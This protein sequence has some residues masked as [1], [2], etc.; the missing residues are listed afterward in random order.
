[1]SG[2]TIKRKIVL[3][4]IITAATGVLI[5]ITV[6]LFFIFK[7]DSFAVLSGKE[8][9]Y[10]VV[11]FITAGGILLIGCFSSIVYFVA[12][13]RKLAVDLSVLI[14]YLKNVL[15]GNP[16]YEFSLNRDDE[17]AVL[18]KE[19]KKLDIIERLKI[20][21]AEDRDQLLENYKLVEKVV[22]EIYDSVTS[23]AKTVENA[24]K[25]FDIIVSTI[26]D[27]DNTAGRTIENYKQTRTNIENLFNQIV[28]S[29][30]SFRRLEEQTTKI[31][32][33]V[34]LISEVAEQT[35]LLSL[36]A[37]MEAARAGEA[38]KGFAVVASEVRKLADRS[39]KEA[40]EIGDLLQVIF[41]TVKGISS[42]AEDSTRSIEVIKSELKRNSDSIGSIFEITK[43]AVSKFDYVQKSVDSVMTL[44]LENTKN[45]DKIVHVNR[46]LKVIIKELS[47][48]IQSIGKATKPIKAIET[49]P[50][51]PIVEKEEVHAGE[52]NDENME[53]EELESVE[54]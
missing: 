45:A 10:L 17:I 28:G 15:S 34:S 13:G 53:I 4:N 42:M 50:E 2:K 24:T 40:M 21:I 43:K 44:T 48:L 22:K 19:L 33:I 20:A 12:I 38:G 29:F 30:K 32:E 39:S 3:G 5:L 23:Q 49:E 18:A 54:D 31:E 26:R 1:M 11:L 27:I 14:E 16:E 37:A 41:S 52:A 9:E 46:S 47:D 7:R 25:G 51:I 35:D 36:N 6:L 8:R